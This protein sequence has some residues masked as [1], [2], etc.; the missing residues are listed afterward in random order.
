MWAGAP[1][2]HSA[3]DRSRCS[4]SATTN[5][6]PPKRGLVG[7]A[8]GAIAVV[9]EPQNRMRYRRRTTSLWRSVSTFMRQTHMIASTADSVSTPRF[10]HTSAG[11]SKWQVF[12]YGDISIVNSFSLVIPDSPCSF[13]VSRALTTRA[14]T[15]VWSAVCSITASFEGYDE[16]NYGVGQPWQHA[17]PIVT[18]TAY[19]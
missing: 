16:L 10:V 15:P 5:T 4:T 14:I 18:D 11:E 12:G 9:S 1:F 19:Q 13:V 2:F 3:A 17:N 7:N 8:H 6:S